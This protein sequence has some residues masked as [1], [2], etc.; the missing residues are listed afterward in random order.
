MGG[1]ALQNITAILAALSFPIWAWVIHRVAPGLSRRRGL[2]LAGGFWL[3]LLT[4]PYWLL[5]P[6][7]FIEFVSEGNFGIAF[8]HYIVRLHPGGLFSFAMAGGQDIY[9]MYNEM[10]LFQVEVAL[11]RI[12]PPWIVVL[13]HKLLVAGCGLGGAYLLAR[14][15]GGARPGSAL[16]AAAAFTCSHLYLLNYSTSFVGAGFAALPFACWV[17]VTQGRSR[18]FFPLAAAATLLMATTDPI[19][20]FPPL[21]AALAACAVMAK[22]RLRWTRALTAFAVMVAAAVINWHEVIYGLA[23]IAPHT[24]RSVG[25]PRTL[26]DAVE[27]G[28]RQLTVCWPIALPLLPALA[29][30]AW[31]RDRFLIRAVAAILT[32]TALFVA[33]D[34]MPWE[35][36]GLAVMRGVEQAYILMAY[37]TVIAPVLARGLDALPTGR[38]LRPAA[39][40][41][42]FA[43]AVTTGDKLRDA[44]QLLWFGGQS[45]Y[46]GYT[47][48]KDAPWRPAGPFRVVTLFDHPHP[49]IIA[50]YYGLESF[51]GG[52]NINPWTYQNY[53]YEVMRREES[54]LRATRTRIDWKYWDGTAYRVAE[55]LRLDLLGAANVRFILS[56]M[57]LA[58]SPEYRLVQSPPEGEVAK[59]PPSSFPSMAAFLAFRLQRVFDPGQLFVYELS[60]TLARAH[61][62][63][64]V[65]V[66]PDEADSGEFHDRIPEALTGAVVLRASDA[67]RLAGVPGGVQVGTM[68]EVIDGLEVEVE[69]PQGGILVVNQYHLPFWHAWVDGRETALVP[70]DGVQ[71]ALAL[72]PGARR[73]TLHYQR[74]L[75]RHALTG[76]R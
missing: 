5:G 45:H 36:I 56:A 46:F 21:A 38:W 39:L 70:A 14:D 15:L 52:V 48:L 59:L 57:P 66:V 27:I 76:T 62:A 42:A 16:A 71:M 60:R 1:D 40:T 49:N 12:A 65:V 28:F 4:L 64:R 18:R 19:H 74:P 50:A 22:D 67:A 61:A 23:A 43:L 9:A 29:G 35:R 73:V 47:A 37:M 10:A 26:I 13:T 54:F 75:L 51:D 31:R 68:R 69:A 6:Y 55:S 53:W 33:A 24:H 2:L 17:L 63:E 44:A 8:F 30:L 7:S 32:V 20:S 25:V 41:L 11:F 72:P 34:R 58:D 3:L